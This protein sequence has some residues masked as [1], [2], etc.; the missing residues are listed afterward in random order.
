MHGAGQ[1]LAD[2]ALLRFHEDASQ[3]DTSFRGFQ[4][5]GIHV[6][7]ILQVGVRIIL[8]AM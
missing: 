6:L 8:I 2:S 1:L 4:D 7:R 3:K 5:L